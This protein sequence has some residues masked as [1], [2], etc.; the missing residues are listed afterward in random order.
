MKLTWFIAALLV[1]IFLIALNFAGPLKGS[2][3][4]DFADGYQPES[5][6][7]PGCPD[8]PNCVLLSIE[9]ESGAESLYNIAQL[10]L[11]EM[12]PDKIEISSQSLQLKAVFQIPVFGFNDDFTVQITPSQ[13]HEGAVLH[14]SSRSRIGHSDLGVNRRRAK[15][16]LR[17]LNNHT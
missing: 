3:S 17:K 6:P 1:I 5:N 2:E 15:T 12:E 7:L 9:T 16:F 10:I 11:E 8:S 4:T 14:L 13:N